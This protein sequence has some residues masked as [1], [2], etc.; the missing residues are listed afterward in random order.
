MKKLTYLLSKR[1]VYLASMALLISACA[2]D[3]VVE[4]VET[5]EE[6]EYVTVHNVV[7]DESTEATLEDNLIELYGE[8]YMLYVQR[9][10]VT[11]EINSAD[12]TVLNEFAYIDLSDVRIVNSVYVSA[13]STSE[14]ADG[15][16][17][18]AI[19]SDGHSIPRYAFAIEATETATLREIILPNDLNAIG[20][21]A[22]YGNSKL[23]R[24]VFK[25][26]EVAYV[27]DVEY[28][29]YGNEIE[30]DYDLNEISLTIYPGAFSG[31]KMLTT[32]GF[33]LSPVRNV[34]MILE[35][36][37]DNCIGFLDFTIPSGVE[38]LGN[39]VF[40]GCTSLTSV[41]IP[42]SV[43]E[44]GSSMFL[45]CT[46]L[47]VVTVSW[48][49][50]YLPTID[51]TTFPSQFRTYSKTSKIVI[52]DSATVSDY[53]G[54]D[55]WNYYVMVNSASQDL[56]AEEAYT[57]FTIVAD[58]TDLDDGG[59]SSNL[60]DLMVDYY[61]SDFMDEDKTF[62][63][64]IL[65]GTITANDFQY[66]Q[67]FKKVDLSLVDG[68]D[69]YN[70]IPT[71]AYYGAGVL[72]D[73]AFMDNEKI[74]YYAAPSSLSHTV[75][76]RAFKNC[77]NLVNYVT[78]TSTTVTI[79][80]EEAFMGCANMIGNTSSVFYFSSTVPV[81][82]GDRAFSGCEALGSLDFRVT[83][84]TIGSGETVNQYDGVQ[85]IG[86]EAFKDCETLTSLYF[87]RGLRSIGEYAFDGCDG[88]T[89]I[90][91]GWTTGDID[92]IE[93]PILADGMFPDDFA[94]D[95]VGGVANDG[96][97]YTI[98]VATGTEKI[99]NGVPGWREYAMKNDSAGVT[100]FD[101]NTIYLPNAAGS[102]YTNYTR[103]EFSDALT[104]IYDANNE[105]YDNGAEEAPL[106]IEGYMT[107]G[108]AT[109]MKNA[110][111][112]NMWEE[113][114]LSGTYLTA[115]CNGMFAN[116]T[117]L[118]SVTFPETLATLESG[119]FS[120]TVKEIHFGWATATA[121]T[122]AMSNATQALGSYFPDN[123]K[124]GDT[125]KIYVTSGVYET[126]LAAMPGYNV[127]S[128]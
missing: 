114:D 118:E 11:G 83:N 74:E 125:G 19:V 37:F 115:V 65:D 64:L 27:P 54:I 5:E 86:E 23:E 75:G 22:F 77:V 7:P 56:S 121:F 26:P 10:K 81:T 38:K 97:E 44:L 39:Q 106:V 43:E 32:E 36:A 51:L 119:M 60:Y 40:K 80:D 61:G 101:V 13:T 20:K 66:M 120:G 124:T 91:M 71:G 33:D 31:C 47:D 15:L 8:S 70:D 89:T 112:G 63:F 111:A 100:P 98:V 28:D 59:T 87:S 108:D 95:H 88:L 67:N 72:P 48:D 109:T 34:D 25:A 76:K 24:V 84:A 49:I 57:E 35:N 53:Q 107:T 126:A 78:T 42:S 110:G 103:G 113:I 94:E 18:T 29:E 12:F 105:Y 90:T 16:S 99:Y 62:D 96:A 68:I 82:V 127:V 52:P 104:A 50:D 128:E 122:N 4:N 55:G 6:S 117:M 41:E 17:Y 3:E 14:S 1:F 69:F 9:I 123:F 73:E 92:F 46:E 85:S 93:I 2:K 58:D 45:D 116:A 21:S 79:Y 102:Y 30:S